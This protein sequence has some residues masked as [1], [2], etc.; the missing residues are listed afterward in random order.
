MTD[1]ANT[2][3]SAGQPWAGRHFEPNASVDD[4]GSA[5]PA[6]LAAIN[7]FHTGTGGEAQVVEVFRTSRL[8][9]PLLT[10]L[11]DSGVNARGQKVDKSQELSIV[12]VE[13]PDGRTV[14]PVFSS[15]SAMGAWNSVARPVPA[16]GP[17][18]AAAAVSEGTDLVILDPTAD[19]EFAVRRPALW[20]IVKD[21]T[22]VPSYRS[23][24]V[25]R[26]FAVSVADEP[27]VLGVRLTAGDPDARMH[28]PELSVALTL[29]PGLAEIELQELLARL[30]SRWES[31]EVIAQ[32]VD[33]LEV[34]LTA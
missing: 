4:D 12:T 15:V 3:D 18:V 23:E 11:G 8:L 25:A 28:G 29:V 24:D 10:A 1:R 2:A 21:E 6:L 31:S 14:L 22:W 34:S 17:R 7:D 33:S 9:I 20:T 27:V 16:S 26:A 32:Q 13:G 19:T 5:P 30:S